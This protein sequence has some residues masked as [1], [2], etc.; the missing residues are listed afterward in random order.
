MEIVDIVLTKLKKYKKMEYTLEEVALAVNEVKQLVLNYCNIRQVPKG[1]N[2]TVAEMCVDLLRYEWK[3]AQEDEGKAIFG[4][5]K[6]LKVGR[7]EAGRGSSSDVDIEL[8]SHSAN[9]D[10]LILNY[11]EMLNRYRVLTW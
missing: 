4:N 1:L 6:T 5:L 11:R 2:Y 10:D 7:V 8:K 9:L 3:R